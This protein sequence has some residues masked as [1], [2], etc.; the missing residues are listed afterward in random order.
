MPLS[1][2]GKAS[3]ASVIDYKTEYAQSLIDDFSEADKMYIAVS[4]AG[5]VGYG[6]HDS[7]GC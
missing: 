2:S 1:A 6:H 7:W 5:Y 3:F 4:V